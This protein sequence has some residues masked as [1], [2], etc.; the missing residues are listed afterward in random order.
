M[1]SESSM[2]ARLF[3]TD[4]KDNWW[5]GPLLTAIGLG[6]FGIY[7]FWAALQGV[8]YEFGPYLSPFYSPL[9]KIEGW[10]L[11]PAFLILWAPLGFRATC[12]YYRKAYYRSFFVDPPAC[13]V[14]EFRGKRYKGETSFP[15]IIQ[16]VHRYFMYVA[17]VFII[18][19]WSD[20]VK[21]VFWDDGVH[22]GLGTLIMAVN[23]TLLT[24][25]TFGCHALRHLVGGKF[26]CFGCAATTPAR[27]KAYQ[28]VSFLTGR[29]MLFAWCSLFAV[30]FTD[31]YIRMCSMG[32]FTDLRIF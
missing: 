14:G 1:S 24:G 17:L 8:H 3:L 18:L 19:L 21:S 30:G 2:P 25:Y 4:R 23:T 6:G 31:F 10:P 29:H 12:Y 7:S 5:L 15:F 13:G 9:I 32:V 11:S 20:V 28:G 27:F 16:N 22:L 26:D